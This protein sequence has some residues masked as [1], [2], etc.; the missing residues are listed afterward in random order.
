MPNRTVYLP[1]ELDDYAKE[2][3]LPLSQL[4][5]TAV[6][7]LIDSAPRVRRKVAPKKVPAKA[8]RAAGV[9]T[10]G[11]GSGISGGILG[12]RAKKVAP[13]VE[14]GITRQWEPEEH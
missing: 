10:R 5:Q 11:E 2:H 13:R 7:A 3:E 12:E 4:L 8:A 9:I 6:Q 14:G 1:K